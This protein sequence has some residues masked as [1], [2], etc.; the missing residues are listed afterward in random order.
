MQIKAKKIE[1]EEI[2]NDIKVEEIKNDI[3]TDT[4]NTEAENIE[5]MKLEIYEH[6]YTITE[7]IKMMEKKNKTYLEK[8][9]YKQI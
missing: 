2:D 6:T 1:E 7:L 5:E 8:R 4:L 9:N 3:D